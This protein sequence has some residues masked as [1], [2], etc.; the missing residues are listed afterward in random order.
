[1]D[2]LGSRLTPAKPSGVNNVGQRGPDGVE[3]KEGVV[4]LVR[5]ISW[6][7]AAMFRPLMLTTAWVYARFFGS[8]SGH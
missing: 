6:A 5:T 1:V 4:G 7:Y 8:C 2:V 3:L